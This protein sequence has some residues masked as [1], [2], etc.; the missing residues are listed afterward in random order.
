[1]NNNAI[2]I[3]LFVIASMSCTVIG[4]LLLKTGVHKSG[5]SSIWPLSLLNA[6]T[7]LG[8][9]SFVFAMV[10]YMMVLKRTALNL[11]QSIF[12]LQFV[13]VII[14]ANVILQEPIGLQRWLGIGLIATGL[15]VISL[16]PPT[17]LQ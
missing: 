14:A 13:L 1:M 11:A 8:A 2:V 10:F 15:F 16:T 9:V 6:H 12:A 17:S 5:V 4:N 3:G 7:L